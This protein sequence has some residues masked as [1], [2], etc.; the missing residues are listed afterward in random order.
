MGIS[1]FIKLGKSAIQAKESVDSFEPQHAI[2]LGKKTATAP[3]KAYEN[4]PRWVVRG[5]QLLFGIIIVGFYGHRVDVD[6]R[7]GTGQ[8]AEWIYGVFVSGLS[9][10]I[11]VVFAVMAPAGVVSDKFK[12]HRLFFCDLVLFILWLIAFG[13]FAG[14]F[15]KRD[16]KLDYKGASTKVY[17]SSVWVD[18]VNVILWLISGVYGAI[19]TLLGRK[20]DSMGNRVAGKLFS[21]KKSANTRTEHKE[22]YGV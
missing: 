6:R 10:I 4:I 18:L 15:L 7:A 3:L 19:K 9:C 1:T 22:W 5:L 16:D 17:R 12:T 11:A 8:S 20:V 21:R 2:N 13:V 14:I